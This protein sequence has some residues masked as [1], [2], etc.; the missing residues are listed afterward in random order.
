MTTQTTS[1]TDQRLP[2]GG[3]VGIIA[4]GGMLPVEV[5]KSLSAKGKP[6]FILI[7]EGEVTVHLDELRQFEHETLAL[8]RLG[9]LVTVLQRHGVTHLVLAGEIKRRP[10]LSAIKINLGLLKVLPELLK[11]LTRGDD[12]LLRIVIR[13]FEARGITIVGAQDIVPDILASEM[14]LTKAIPR[15]SDWS[16]IEV[17]FTAAKTIGRLDIGQAAVSIGSRVIALEGIEG[18]AGLLDRV[19]GLRGHGRLAGRQRGVLVKCAKPQQELRVDLPTIGPETIESAH[20]AGLAGVVVEANRSIVL[21]TASV[22][23]K[24]DR[25]G[26]FVLGLRREELP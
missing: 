19:K 15:K 1:E 21:D 24:A 17:A 2:A 23:E 26:M 9:N 14:V 11:A 18:T 6:P 5:A 16:D 22:I 7:V 3:K 20:A 12:G 10:K 25:Y 13:G 4:G 8:E